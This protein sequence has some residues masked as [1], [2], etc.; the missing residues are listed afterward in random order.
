MAE[1]SLIYHHMLRELRLHVP[2]LWTARRVLNI[3]A[4]RCANP[5]LVD[6][7]KEA[8]AKVHLL[9]AWDQNVTYYRKKDK[10]KFASIAQGDVR[11]L[12]GEMGLFDAVVWW[13]GPEHLPADEWPIAVRVLE[14]MA[15]LVI[16]GCPWGMWEQG[17]ADGNPF[18][19]HQSSI[20]PEDLTSC[21][22]TVRAIGM[23]ADN[24]SYLVA[25]IGDSGGSKDEWYYA[26][27]AES[28]TFWLVRDGQREALRS[29]MEMYAV[30]LLPIHVLAEDE[31]EAIPARKVGH[32]FP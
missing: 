31:L 27:L 21:G 28:P 20:Y 32:A 10:T 8:G 19:V 5:G 2:N 12:P 23:G 25:W 4:N 16:L 22:Y 24:S 29:P 17:E 15:P 6:E 30:G 7:L 18:E 11:D 13:H 9:E 1:V 14:S 26:K 3:G